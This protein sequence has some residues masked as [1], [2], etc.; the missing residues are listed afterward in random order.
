MPWLVEAV[1]GHQAFDTELNQLAQTYGPPAG[2][3]LIARAGEDALGGDP[4]GAGAI[5]GLTDGVCEMKRLFVSARGR[6]LGLGR[7]LA[8]GLIA[9]ARADGFKAMRLDT[10]RRLTEAISLYETLGFR[11]IPAYRHYPDD[12]APHLLFM[13]IAL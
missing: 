2:R 8:E 13:E 4:V 3:L 1:F 10:A 5:R 11:P 7:A 9:Q 12:L 6:G